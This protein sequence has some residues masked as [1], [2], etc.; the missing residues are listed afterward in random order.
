MMLFLNIVNYIITNINYIYNTNFY[1]N[2]IEE[3]EID[4]KKEKTFIY[5]SNCIFDEFPKNDKQVTLFINQYLFCN[6]NCYHDKCKKF[7][8]YS[9]IKNSI[10]QNLYCY[11]VSNQYNQFENSDLTISEIYKQMYLN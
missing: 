4:G 7:N 9:H 11:V 6:I 1:F 3:K 5:Y 10:N 8:K 2:N